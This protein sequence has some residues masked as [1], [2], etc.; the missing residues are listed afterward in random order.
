[1][2]GDER[3]IRILG[4]MVQCFGFDA[5][6]YPFCKYTRGIRRHVG[7]TCVANGVYN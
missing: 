6:H 7:D 5:L 2:S 4:D 1:M 3:E